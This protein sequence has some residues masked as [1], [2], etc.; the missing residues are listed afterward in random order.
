MSRQ[1]NRINDKTLEQSILIILRDN[2][3][4]NFIE[5][6]LKPNCRIIPIEYINENIRLEFLK[7][8]MDTNIIINDKIKQQFLSKMFK[9]E[10]KKSTAKMISEI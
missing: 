8:K 6:L 9:K 2:Y 5:E 4:D 1:I 7:N 3:I 10:C